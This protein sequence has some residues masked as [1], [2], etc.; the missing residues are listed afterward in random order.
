MGVVRGYQLKHELLPSK[1]GHCGGQSGASWRKLRA[2]MKLVEVRKVAVAGAFC[3]FACASFLMVA[4]Y[5]AVIWL[6]IFIPAFWIGGLAGG[7]ALS[8]LA[9]SVWNRFVQNRKYPDMDRS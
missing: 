4:K 2:W 1:T 9:A 3:G 6:P 5:Q 7:A 8:G